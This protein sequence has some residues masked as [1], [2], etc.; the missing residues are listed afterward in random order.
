MYPLDHRFQ[1]LGALILLRVKAFR[2]PGDAVLVHQGEAE[3]ML[4][5]GLDNA[6]ERGEGR[7]KGANRLLD[8]NGG[9]HCLVFPNK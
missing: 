3:A 1:R 4:A 2:V 7:R 8:L 6:V 9:F 5:L